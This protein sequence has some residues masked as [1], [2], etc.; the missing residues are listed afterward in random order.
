ME[1]YISQSTKNWDMINICKLYPLLS[2]FH[3]VKSIV[4]WNFVQKVMT[5]ILEVV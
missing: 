3:R 1:V 4:I 2:S 5:I